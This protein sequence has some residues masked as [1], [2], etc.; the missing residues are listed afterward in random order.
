MAAVFTTSRLTNGGWP[1]A[2]W[3]MGAPA[4]STEVTDGAGAVAGR[5]SGPAQAVN[6]ATPTTN[7]TAK[8]AHEVRSTCFI[9]VRPVPSA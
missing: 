1:G 8:R 2:S 7:G 3:G 4:A 5:G 6:A 9:V